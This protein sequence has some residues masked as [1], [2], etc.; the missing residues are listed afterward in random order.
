MPHIK[1]VHAIISKNQRFLLGKRSLLKDKQ[2]GCWATIG[3]RLEV[4]ETLELALIRECREEVN[5]EAKPVRKLKEIIGN[6]V[7]HYWFEVEIES[8]DPVI[9]NDEHTELNWFE[10][11]DLKKL[12]PINP[13]DLKV[14]CSFF[15]FHQ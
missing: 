4:D 9:A 12:R 6:D 11:Q 15:D 2:P 1:V 3:G 8:G 10:I 14:I 13:E 7:S 5:I